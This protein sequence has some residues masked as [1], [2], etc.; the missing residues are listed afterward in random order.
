MF[1]SQLSLVNL[2]VDS[3]L[4]LERTVSGLGGRRPERIRERRQTDVCTSRCGRKQSRQSRSR[5][6]ENVPRI[7]SDRERL[8]FGNP[9]AFLHRHIRCP[10]V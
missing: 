1:N 6:V 2:E 10:S 9:K 3:S 4:Q 8:G 7:D 5:M